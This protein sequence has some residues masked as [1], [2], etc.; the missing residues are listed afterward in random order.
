MRKD[1]KYLEGIQACRYLGSYFVPLN[2]HSVATEIEHIVQDS[3]AKILIAHTDLVHPFNVRNLRDVLLAILPTPTE[4]AKSYHINV[5]TRSNPVDMALDLEL[6]LQTAS[7]ID[8]QPK[9]FRG[10]FA[11]TSGITGRPKGIKRK[12]DENAG[13][14]YAMYQGLSHSLM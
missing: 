5:N 11:Y 8:T 10:M 12:T 4:V 7:Q 1:V 9:A 6:S 13:D 2:W 14:K 3:G